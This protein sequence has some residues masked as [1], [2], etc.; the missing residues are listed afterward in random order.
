MKGVCQ[1]DNLFVCFGMKP[2]K[3]LSSRSSTRP[4]VGKRMPVRGVGKR[5][6]EEAVGKGRRRGAVDNGQQ[7]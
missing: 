3:G 6:R 4:E 5:N 2:N 1:A 7:K